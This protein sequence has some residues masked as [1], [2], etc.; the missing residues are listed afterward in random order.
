MIF[1]LNFSCISKYFVFNHAFFFNSLICLKS[2]VN[3]QSNSEF[4]NLELFYDSSIVF[5]SCT[6]ILII[7]VYIF[8]ISNDFK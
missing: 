5:F 4:Q 6:C 7:L 3:N 8:L 1:F 2:L